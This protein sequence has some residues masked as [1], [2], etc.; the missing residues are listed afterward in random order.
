RVARA[1]GPGYPYPDYPYEVR[2]PAGYTPERPW[3]VFLWVNGK[4]TS[5]GGWRVWDAALPDTI[6]VSP[7]LRADDP[8][9]PD[10]PTYATARAA[11]MAILPDLSA[12]FA[13]DT[14]RV[15]VGGFSMGGCFAWTWA[16]A[17]GDRLA[18]SVPGAGFAT[19]DPRLAANCLGVPLWIVQGGK[20]PTITEAD[21][22]AP[23]P[24]LEGAGA[25]FVWDF[26]PELG[27]S[28]PAESMP[29]I[30][31]WLAE[32][33]RVPEPRRIAQVMASAMN[34][35]GR[36][37]W[38]RLTRWK[39][40]VDLG[41][42]VGEDNEVALTVAPLEGHDPPSLQGLEVY[43]ND[44]LVDLDRPVTVRLNGR[45]V[46]RGTV[47][48]DPALAL[49]LYLERRDLARIH[50]ARVVVEGEDLSR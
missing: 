49:D 7:R 11:F 15:S 13:V 3:P 43:L 30:A 23:L 9:N 25:E 1:S 28:L 35:W 26:H 40:V 2:L 41:A 16:I 14:D 42:E 22:R 17:L 33:R 21:F 31:G 12:S 47:G 20:D 5:D 18:A 19:R 39:G 50:T 46:H 4:G 8:A 27:H 36:H 10:S 32:R 44:A 37:A 38:V 48:R 24:V 6:L 34:P 45:E 29:R